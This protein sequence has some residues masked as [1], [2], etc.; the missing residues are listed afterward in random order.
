[1]EPT[2]P[3]TSSTLIFFMLGVLTP[4]VIGVFVIVL[5]TAIIIDITQK[6]F[7]WSKKALI[8]FVVVL[9]IGFLISFLTQ[10]L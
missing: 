8:A 3:V 2:Q 1:M 5:I 7:N 10:L 6:K 9:G 4:I